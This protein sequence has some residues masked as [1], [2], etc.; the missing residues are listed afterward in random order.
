[1]SRFGLFV[2]LSYMA[3][4]VAAP[5]GSTYQ[6]THTSVLWEETPAHQS[7]SQA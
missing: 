3:S 5:N 1:M 4:Q 7:R 2:R 6:S